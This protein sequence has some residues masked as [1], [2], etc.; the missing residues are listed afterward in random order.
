LTGSIDTFQVRA[1][2]TADVRN[3]VGCASSLAAPFLVGDKTRLQ[4]LDER[5]AYLAWQSIIEEKLTLNLYPQQVKQA[6]TQF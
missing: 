1:L 2:C 5:R 6:E 3:G 4:D